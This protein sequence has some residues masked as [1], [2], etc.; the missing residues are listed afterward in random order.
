[1]LAFMKIKL[2]SLVGAVDSGEIDRGILVA[3][4]AASGRCRRRQPF[5]PPRTTAAAHVDSQ[6]PPRPHDEYSA[7]TTG[8][9]SLP[10]FAKKKDFLSKNNHPLIAIP[11]PPSMLETRLWMF[12]HVFKLVVSLLLIRI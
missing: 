9:R 11:R 6:S 2:S 7:E 12:N 8:A 1:M 3:L 4:E 10:I 5:L